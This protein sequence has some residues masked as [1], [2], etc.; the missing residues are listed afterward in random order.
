MNELILKRCKDCNTIVKVINGNASDLSCCGKPLEE[1]KANTSDGAMEKHLPS[2]EKIGEKIK[3]TVNHVMEK[4]HY[5]EWILVKTSTG[6]QERFLRPEEEPVM[7]VPYE[8]NAKIYSFCNK[9]G[10]WETEV[11]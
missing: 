10:L 6:S 9:H 1:I 7:I 5:I 3:I 8:P 4:D 2:Y 11:K